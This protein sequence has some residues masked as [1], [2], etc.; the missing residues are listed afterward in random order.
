M[1]CRI[2]VEA[3]SDL[4]NSWLYTVENWSLEQADRYINL[5][6]DEFKYLSNNPFTG[7]DRS[8]L[9]KGYRSSKV[10]SLVIFYLIDQK[11]NEIEIVRILHERM[12]LPNRLND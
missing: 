9:C 4:E 7:N 1:R 3:K 5:L 6:L 12:D 11:R 2:S 8:N 10:K